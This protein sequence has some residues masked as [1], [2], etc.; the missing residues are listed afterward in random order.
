MPGFAKNNSLGR[1]FRQ[2]DNGFAR[3]W[4]TTNTL[5]KR[6]NGEPVNCL[7]ADEPE[8]SRANQS[9]LHLKVLLQIASL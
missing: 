6:T 2:K 1:N 9:T 7:S 8:C 4:S 3:I 5:Y